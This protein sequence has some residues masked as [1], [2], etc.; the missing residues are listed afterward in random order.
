MSLS[1]LINRPATII[2]RGESTDTDELG[3]EVP[4]ET[5]EDVV[6]ELQQVRRDEDD[7]QGET[8]DT[9]WVAYFLPDTEL[10]T[11][12]ALEVDGETYELVGDPWQARSPGTDAVSHVEVGLRRTAGANDE[13]EAS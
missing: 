12:D 2:R 6:C 1:Q 8:S 10:N 11:G 9:D 13:V 7:Q 4:E 3:N 5:T